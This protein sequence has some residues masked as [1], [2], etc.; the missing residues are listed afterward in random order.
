VVVR[1]TKK[2]VTLL[3]RGVT[4][5]E[6]TPSDDDWYANLLWIDRRKCLLLVH[7]HTLFPVFRVDVRAGDLRPLEPYVVRAIEEEL[8]AE[9]LPLDVLGQLDADEVHIAKTASR[10]VLGHMNDM[11]FHIR[12]QIDHDGGLDACDV[13]VLN[14]RQRRTLHNRGGIYAEPLDLVAGRLATGS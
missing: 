14:H 5:T 13:R 6:Q 1:C 7:A 10:A 11:A 8:H 3:G 4:F 2:L 9:G 12:Y